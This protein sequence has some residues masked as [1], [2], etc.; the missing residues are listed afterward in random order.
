M[1]ST[2]TLRFCGSCTR[3]K[4]REEREIPRA[5]EPLENYNSD[6]KTLY[7]LTYFKGE[8]FKVGDGVYLHPEAFNF[9]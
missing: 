8:Q 4:E 1:Y 6:T 7:A 5:F 9:R 2:F 3:T